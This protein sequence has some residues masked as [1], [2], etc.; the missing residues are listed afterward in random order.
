MWDADAILRGLDL[1]LTWQNVLWLLIGFTTGMVVGAIPGLVESTYLAIVLPFTLYM[2]IWTALFF[3]TGAYVGAEAAGSY[4]AILMNM[5]G[6]PGTSAT[7]FEGYPLTKKGFPGQ[8]VG[9]SVA[10]SAYGTCVGALIFMFLGPLF[11]AFAL[12]F[13]SPELFMLGVFGMTAVGSL[14]GESVL[15]GL[16]SA[17]LGLL[18]A[19]TGLDLFNGLPRAHFGLLEVYD[20]IPVVPALLGL[21][22]LSEILVLAN[23][24]YIVPPELV[25]SLGLKAPLEGV[26]EAF[27]HPFVLF[28]STLIGMIIGIIPGTGATAANVIAY[29]QAKQWSRTPERFGT[30][31]YEGLVASDSSNNSVVPGALIPTFT[32]G[33][34]GSGTAV[35]MLAAMM[36][37]GV[38]PGPGFY[39]A[40]GMQA[41][42]I[43]WSLLLCTAFIAMI[44][45]PFAGTFARMALIPLKALIPLISIACIV[46]VF[47]A[48]QYLV[49]IGIMVVFGLIGFII[50]RYGY[51]PVALLLALI[52]GPLLEHNFFRSLAVGG[53]SIFFTK[54]ISL[55]LVVLSALSLFLPLLLKRA[56]KGEGAATEE[57]PAPVN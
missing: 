39:E 4:P 45:L 22:G 13:G 12:N 44:A 57:E 42:A 6:T 49:D 30:G 2:D 56:G 35:I 19:T 1:L 38:R 11:A 27:R 55:T 37:Q 48:R 23:R 24:H 8:A 28:R 51:S 52:L 25:T 29:A 17:A 18:I 41:Y 7:T 54:P 15:K 9:C 26:R 20:S 32:L 5:P 3:M 46:G 36:L 40:Y 33:I 50:R 14:T 31:T 21:F 43:G 16:I 10:A 34:P 53:W 47:S